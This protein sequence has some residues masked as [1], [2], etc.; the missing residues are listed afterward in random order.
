MT[1]STFNRH[2]F[3]FKFLRHAGLILYKIIVMQIGKR[4]YNTKEYKYTK[5]GKISVLARILRC[6]FRKIRF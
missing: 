5:N 1:Y 4:S 6:E 3:M 2:I